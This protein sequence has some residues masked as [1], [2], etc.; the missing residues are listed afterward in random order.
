LDV[1]CGVS[2]KVLLLLLRVV[3]LRRVAWVEGS[4]F[5]FLW[6]LP[7]FTVFAPK[8]DKPMVLF[9]IGTRLNSWWKLIRHFPEIIEFFKLAG[10]NFASVATP[11]PSHGCLASRAW[12]GFDFHSSVVTM[13]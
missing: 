5:Y 10:R 6:F 3:D 13:A 12:G 7:R 1:L 8:S 9:M 4:F 2:W 11:S